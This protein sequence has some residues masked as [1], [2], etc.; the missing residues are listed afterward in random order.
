MEEKDYILDFI[1]KI[2]KM[3]PSL[4]TCYEGINEFIKI[5]FIFTKRS[6]VSVEK[7][8]NYVYEFEHAGDE[9]LQVCEVENIEEM[10]Q[11]VLDEPEMEI[12]DFE[13]AKESLLFILNN[14]LDELN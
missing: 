9:E 8:Y 1:E 10:R 11:M 7:C 13:E 4:T 5:G 12:I 2:N 14:R 3:I 6:E